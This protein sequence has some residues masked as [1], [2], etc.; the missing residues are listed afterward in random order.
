MTSL[1]SVD[2][3]GETPSTDSVRLRD[4]GLHGRRDDLLVGFRFAGLQL[5]QCPRRGRGR[6]VPDRR[7]PRGDSVLVGVLRGVF[8]AFALIATVRDPVLVGIQHVV[9]ARAETLRVADPVL[10]RVRA[11]AVLRDVVRANT[12]ASITDVGG[13]PPSP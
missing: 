3:R 10:V 4:R 2:S 12:A 8:V 1:L 6:R 7:D 9:E 5:A 11:S 13:R